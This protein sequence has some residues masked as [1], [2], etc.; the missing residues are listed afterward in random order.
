MLLPLA[1]A[2]PGAGPFEVG[3]GVAVGPGRRC[4]LRHGGAE[5]AHGERGEHPPQGDVRGGRG[6][7]RAERRRP[8]DA[9]EQLVATRV[10]DDE[11][12]VAAEAGP[13]L[14]HQVGRHE[15]QV[16]GEDGDHVGGHR[17]AGPPRSA[18]TGPPPAGCSRT[19]EHAVR[20]RLGRADDHPLRR[21]GDGGEDGVQYRCAADDQPRLRAAAEPGAPAAGQHHR[22]VGRQRWLHEPE[23]TARAGSPFGTWDE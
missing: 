11:H 16:A 21:V 12:A 9:E 4:A 2:D 19:S 5:A 15:R 22:G 10:V 3:R 1:G 20:H 8:P 6:Q 18:A 14:V 23:G 7:G 13:E 17:G